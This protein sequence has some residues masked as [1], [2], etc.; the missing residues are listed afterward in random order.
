MDY[1]NTL[2]H[3]YSF[4]HTPPL[5]RALWRITRNFIASNGLE[6]V[7]H[8]PVIQ[9]TG[10]NGKGSTAVF[11]EAMLAQQTGT[12]LLTSPHT[13]SLRGRIRIDGLLIT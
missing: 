9:I 13:Y 6:S 8:A 1:E 12:L 5:S 7:R 11:V 2:N 3:L 4:Y 10:T